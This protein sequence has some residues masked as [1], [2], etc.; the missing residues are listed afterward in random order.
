MKDRSAILKLAVLGAGPVVALLLWGILSTTTDLEADAVNTAAVLGLMA[1]W[2]LTE[3]IPLPATALLPLALFPALDIASMKAAA[4][5]FAKP[6][7]FLFL[8]GFLLAKGLERWGLHKRIA[9][10]TIRIVG[11]SPNRLIG[12]FMVATALMSMWM[13]NTATAIMLLPVALSVISL[14]ERE[15]GESGGAFSTCLLLGLAYA[16][17]IGGVGTP[18]GTPPNVIL[19]QYLADQNH[20]VTFAR[21]MLVGLPTVLIFLPTTWLMLTR[22]L[23][24][25]R[26][27]ELKGGREL[28]DREIQ[29]LGPIS[30][31]EWTVMAVFGLT[32]LGWLSTGVLKGLES[33][34]LA[35]LNRLH[36]ASIAIFGAILL[37]II[38]VDLRKREFALD[39]KAA[40]GIP[41]GILL[42]FGGGL[43]L[44]D[45]VSS[46]GLS[47]FIAGQVEALGSVPTVVLILCVA[48][49]TIFL[50]EVTSNT[51]TTTIF[52]PILFA[53]AIG[54]G[55]NMDPQLLV[56]PAAIGASCAFM[57]PVATPPNAIV[58]ASGHIRIQQM[59]RAGIWLNILSIIV[60]T[61][62]TYTA[63]TWALGIDHTGVP[64]WVEQP[65][66]AEQSP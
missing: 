59:A 14:V 54:E 63:A 27:K 44:A 48:A 33:P 7:I 15:T 46:T 39:W 23:Y 4:E 13:S 42:L 5:P 16:A 61:V 9:M 26:M 45:A 12:G 64:A 19:V 25:V 22:L 66:P 34:D 38:P 50:T 58:F 30:R 6:T 60:V 49:V 43:S 17:S 2:W 21:W 24:P 56:V 35:F 31:G 10:H 36:D 55:L 29:R 8:G 3:A 32:V 20:P 47:Q 52:V 51:A 37:F 1:T 18:I 28:I 53:M 62:I 40:E 11:T 65:A 41:W 57:M